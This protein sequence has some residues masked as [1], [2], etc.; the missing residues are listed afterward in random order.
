MTSFEDKLTNLLGLVYHFWSVITWIIA[1]IY[2]RTVV[3][4]GLHNIPNDGA[5]M[6]VGNHQNQFVDPLLIIAS[7]PRP[8]GFLCAAKSM[9]GIIGFFAKQLQAIPV[10]RPQDIARKGTGKVNINDAIVTGFGTKFTKEFQDGDSLCVPLTGEVERILKVE[11][12]EKLVLHSAFKKPYEKA[13]YLFYPKVDQNVVYATVEE[14]LGAGRCVG[15]FPEGGSH[16]RTELL[17]IKAGVSLMVLGAMEKYKIPI[18]IVP[19]GLNYF[20]GHRFRGSVLIEFGKAY[21]VPDELRQVYKENKRNACGQVLQVVEELMHSVIVEAPDM[22]TLETVQLVKDLYKP[23]NLQLTS[24]K[25]LELNRKLVDGFLKHRNE[26]RVSQLYEEVRN[27]REKLDNF[28]L[29]DRHI[30]ESSAAI[31]FRT[32]WLVISRFFVVAS[33]FLFALPAIVLNMP[34][35][36]TARYTAKKHAIEAKSKSTVKIDGKDVLSSKKVTTALI[37]LPPFYTLYTIIVAYIWGWKAAIVFTGFLPVLS[38]ASVRMAEEGIALAKSLYALVTIKWIG[39]K[40]KELRQERDILKERVRI[41][42][43]E[44]F[45]DF[46]NIIK[47][48]QFEDQH[49]QKTHFS[50]GK[51]RP[52]FIPEEP[53]SAVF[54]EG[55]DDMKELLS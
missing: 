5:V 20:S 30:E 44:E 18:Y 48:Y 39:I 41:C 3:V 49:H 37:M 8:V 14:R 22:D 12:D 55:L 28:G 36:L 35:G 38:Y 11:S 16:D 17:P 2:F 27:Y 9:T 34:I 24:K 45:G 51:S 26:K 13:S 42:V 1:R 10:S 46:D 54:D 6:F 23:K 19:C 31:G 53:L 4:D 32:W 33:L 25:Y 21:R 7:S 50:L 47:E 43:K 15:I 52:D 40:I 29:K